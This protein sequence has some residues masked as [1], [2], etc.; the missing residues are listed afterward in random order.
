VQ[1]GKIANSTGVI[2]KA[3]DAGYWLIGV[4]AGGSSS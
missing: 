4:H 2:A 3:I 1:S